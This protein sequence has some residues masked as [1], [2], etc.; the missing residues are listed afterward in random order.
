MQVTVGHFGDHVP[1][2]DAHAADGFRHPGGV[3]GE[4]VV[5]VR[6]ADEADD[7]QL[8][9]ELVNDFLHSL[10]RDEAL[11]QVAGK[12]NVK[13]G[14]DAAQGHGRAVLFLHGGQVAQVGP[15]HG[16]AGV[17]GGAAE[18]AAVGGAHPGEFLQG[19]DLFAHFLAQADQLIRK[20][21]IFTVFEILAAFGNQLVRAVQGHAAVVPDDA[22]AA[23]G[24]RKSGDDAGGAGGADVGGVGVENALV[25]RLAYLVENIR[26]FF[27]HLEPVGF[28]GLL[29]HAQ[30][31]EGHQGAFQGSVRLEAHHHFQ[32][33]VNV[34][35]LVGDDGGD[36]FLVRIQHA[37][38]VYFPFQQDFQFLPE[39]ERALGRAGKKLFIAGIGRVVVL[40]EIPYV[41]GLRPCSRLESLPFLRKGGGFLQVFYYADHK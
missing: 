3:P 4:Q 15:L 25:M 28:K 24:V 2:V 37:A 20:G 7:A 29:G 35:G 18:V 27:A 13:E 40:D 38:V 23:V 31:A 12:V 36:H 11:F 5:V 34:A 41:N 30:A 10:F 1:P 22:A 16:F 14:G 21:G 6:R 33:L 26:R 17:P 19:A 32:L 9:H 39:P 8:H